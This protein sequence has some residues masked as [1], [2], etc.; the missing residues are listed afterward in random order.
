MC[1][2]HRAWVKGWPSCSSP[3][4][5]RQPHTP[6]WG[7][8][9]RREGHLVQCAQNALLCARLCADWAVS[10]RGGA[11]SLTLTK[12][13]L[14]VHELVPTHFLMPQSLSIFHPSQLCSGPQH[15]DP[16]KCISL[17]FSLIGFGQWEA[18]SEIMRLEE[19]DV[20]CFL[21]FSSGFSTNPA[22]AQCPNKGCTS[23]D[24]GSCQGPP[25]QLHLSL[26]YH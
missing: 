9:P 17:A 3:T 14:C 24:P 25:S 11:L 21:P 19:R 7:C 8:I 16:L 2:A 5:I 13:H 23:W 4:F 22:S 6:T 26:R 20:G 15:S 10:T 18:L 12:W 1:R